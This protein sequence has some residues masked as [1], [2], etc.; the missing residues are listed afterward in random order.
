MLTLNR[1][2][3]VLFLTFFLPT[4]RLA[5]AN[6]LNDLTNQ[7]LTPS[8]LANL[9]AVVMELGDAKRGAILFHQPH[10]Q[11]AQC[12][13]TDGSR[14][15]GPDLARP[16]SP[17]TRA[18]LL[19]S[20]IQPSAKI[21]PEFRTIAVFTTDGKR[22]T[23]TFVS[24]D[25]RT[26]KFRDTDRQGEL[27]QQ[28][29]RELEEWTFLA[30]SLM[31]DGLLKQLGSTQQ[32]YD[33]A[34]Y[35]IEISE[36]GP[37]RAEQLRPPASLTALPP[38][39]AYE[40]H[41][42]HA[43]IIEDWNE[44]SLERGRQIYNRVCAN[45]HGTQEREGSL[46]TAPRFAQDKLKNGHQPLQLYRTLTHGAGLMVA[47]RWMVPQQKYDVIHYLRE[48]YFRPHN[49]QLYSRVDRNYLSGLPQGN[50]RGPAPTHRLD[51]YIA[52]NYGPSLIHTYEIEV[53][54]SGDEESIGWNLGE[55]PDASDPWQDPDEYFAPGDAPNFAYKGI[56]IRLDAGPGGITRGANWMVYDH[57]TMRMHAAWSG[58]GFI[59]YHSIQFDGRHGCHPRLIGDI[60]LENDVGPGWAH[61]LTGSFSDPRP[62]G[63]DGRPYGPLPRDWYRFRGLY[64]Y[65]QQVI[66]SYEVG[67]ATILETPGV[68]SSE[69]NLVVQRQLQIGPAAHDLRLDLGNVR[70]YAELITEEEDSVVEI[71]TDDDRLILHLSPRDSKVDVTILQSD[72]P[73]S[74]AFAAQVQI[75][76]LAKLTRG[77]PR[78]WPDTV[79]TQVQTVHRDIF[80][81]DELTLPISNPWNCQVRPTGHDFFSDGKRAAV[82]TW[83]GDVWILDGIANDD[84]QLAWQRIASGLFQPLGLK[85]VD[86]QIYLTCRDQLVILRDLNGDLETDYYE[87]FNNDHQ[88]TEHFH[89]F[90]MGL[91]IDEARNFYYAKSARHAKRAVLPHHGTLLKVT[92]D[93]RHTRILATGFRA[94]N[95]V[96]LNPDGTF[97]V[98]DQEGHWNPKNR[99]NWVR[100]GGFY[101]NMYSYTD[102]TDPDDEAM[103]PPLCWITNEFDRSPSELLWV[104]PD[105]WGNLAG[106][107]LNMS[108]G[109]GQLYVVPFEQVGTRRQGG[110]CALPVPRLPSGT[111]RGR[112]HPSRDELYL[113]GMFSWAGSQTRPGTFHRVRYAGHGAYLPVG[114][115]AS[116][117]T[118]EV[119]FS[120][121]LKLQEIGP[122]NISIHTWDLKRTANYG[123]QHYNE[124]ELK[125]ES[126]VVTPSGD[127]LQIHA[128][129]LAPTWGMAIECELK[130]EDGREIVREI[131]NS[132]FQLRPAVKNATR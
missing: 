69:D 126:V 132:I 120:D 81:I 114:I 79:K 10:L 122:D 67:G 100:P 43:A 34:R 41:I 82:C 39:P 124:R 11:C 112:F 57:D 92:P 40:E 70:T 78:R 77:G 102:V 25:D 96:C 33:L 62:V 35:V 21:H 31:P 30:K 5:T 50:T 56:A 63:R 86:E 101:G 2:T 94:A 47:Q 90:A 26:L 110:M 32:F 125:I 115:F 28:P 68:V 118:L 107:L 44:E 49:P 84:G 17:V 113:A 83:D 16:G 76:D 12:H 80:T 106:S 85:I 131:H 53:D 29:L 54:D 87:C 128:P 6:E 20:I 58:V 121:P 75:A 14:I 117:Q 37:E 48:A 38:L 71:Q 127:R 105:K 13:N 45:C 93:G 18:H 74:G 7:E 97:F 42:A 98:T 22:I 103:E 119:Q 36:Q 66:L 95:G 4:G 9:A 73:I 88:V 19:E 123:S 3:F 1:L 65:E 130:L 109:Y 60:H 72:Q 64:H 46:P 8:R 111:M 51:P 129:N 27:T 89:E 24:V 91:Q 116:E 15:I 99:I 108:Y 104:P 52:M 59:D 61:P 55:V 23:G